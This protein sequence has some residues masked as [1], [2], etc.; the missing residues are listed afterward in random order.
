MLDDEPDAGEL[1]AGDS[2]DMAVARDDRRRT[3][4]TREHPGH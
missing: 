4:A 1:A 3:M 2:P